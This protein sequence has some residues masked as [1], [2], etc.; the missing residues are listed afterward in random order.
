MVQHSR[1]DAQDGRAQMSPAFPWRMVTDISELHVGD[2]VMYVPDWVTIFDILRDKDTHHML[3]LMF[4]TATVV[5][6]HELRSIYET[7]ITIEFHH[8]DSRRERNRY[9]ADIDNLYVRIP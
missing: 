5:G 4:T 6:F 9:K 7:M 8:L 2:T 1:P 3:H